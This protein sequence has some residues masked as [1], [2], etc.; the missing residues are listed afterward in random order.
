M[1]LG[2]LRE[3]AP[4]NLRPAVPGNAYEDWM[5]PRVG[6][7]GRGV[8]GGGEGGGG[9]GGGRVG[10]R[11]RGKLEGA[12]FFKGVVPSETFLLNAGGS[13]WARVD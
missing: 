7:G 11:W 5:S 8:G 10:R 12:T 6:G 13:A 1:Q 4:Q 2:R 3:V 9:G